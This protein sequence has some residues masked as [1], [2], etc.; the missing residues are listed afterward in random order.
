MFRK[1]LLQWV[2]VASVRHAF[3]GFNLNTLAFE[4]EQQAGQQRLSV[5]QD[6]ARTTFTEFAAVFS[7][8]Q[9]KIFT[10]HF[11]QR[12]VWGDGDH[13][14]LAIDIQAQVNIIGL[15]ACIIVRISHLF[16]L[17]FDRSSE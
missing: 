5:Y 2:E 8:C 13:Y 16:L 7:S 10:Q 14:L 15:T 6:R 3:D 11:E 1:R 9:Y 12:L 17:I 4:C